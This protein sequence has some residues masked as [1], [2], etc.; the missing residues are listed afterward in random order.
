MEHFSQVICP[1]LS[2]LASFISIY[3]AINIPIRISQNQRYENLLSIYQS[4]D[5]AEALHGVITF[6]CKTCNYDVKRIPYEYKK[7][8]D[9]DLQNKT[10][11]NAKVLHF[12]RRLLTE[13]FSNLDICAR[14]NRALCRKICREFTS[15]ESNIIRILIF[16]NKAVDN[17]KEI[18]M[19]ISK[20]KY[21]HIGKLNG[22][23]NYLMHLSGLLQKSKRWMEF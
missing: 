15:S 2:M 14:S 8:F 4:S 10:L 20:I 9:E 19:D 22:I 16:M 3:V 1:I 5:F 17:N 18:Y 23:N 6:Y 21:E 11:D 13:F 7:R 12:Q